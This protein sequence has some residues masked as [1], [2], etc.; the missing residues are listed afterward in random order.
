MTMFSV[1]FIVDSYAVFYLF[2]FLVLSDRRIFGDD[3]PRWRWGRGEELWKMPRTFSNQLRGHP[4][5]L[6]GRPVEDGG[7]G[8][9][10]GGA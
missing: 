6:Q 9:Q 2:I 3:V 7:G 4:P 10:G 1:Y 5:P 8:V